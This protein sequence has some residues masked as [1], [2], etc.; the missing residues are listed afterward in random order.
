M[1]DCMVPDCVNGSRKTKGSGISYHRLP[2]EQKIQ[3]QRLARIR[4]ENPPKDN[5]CYVCSD[6]F[7]SDCFQ[8]SYKDMFCLGNKHYL[9][10][11]AIPSVFPHSSQV[12]VRTSSLSRIA[13]RDKEQVGRSTKSFPCISITSPTKVLMSLISGY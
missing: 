10:P 9:N 6:H 7:T 12:K 2:N 13:K 1:P 5:S 11:D 3:Q 8:T 4:G